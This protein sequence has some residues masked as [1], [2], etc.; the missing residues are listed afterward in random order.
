M[1]T[2]NMI[3]RQV[4]KEQSDVFMQL[5][6][7]EDVKRIIESIEVKYERTRLRMEKIPVHLR[8][9]SL[10]KALERVDSWEDTEEKFTARMAAMRVLAEEGE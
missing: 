4:A 8:E 10:V 6:S 9:A 2:K 3:L 1:K 5:D 7:E